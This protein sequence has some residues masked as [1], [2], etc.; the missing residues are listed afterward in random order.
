MESLK[1]NNVD[2]KRFQRELQGQIRSLVN[3]RTNLMTR[4]QDQHTEIVTLKRLLGSA[5][6]DSAMALVNEDPISATLV[7]SR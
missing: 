2:A 4:V 6:V 5:A 7:E 3:E 1:A